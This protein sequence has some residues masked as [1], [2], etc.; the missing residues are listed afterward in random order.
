MEGSGLAGQALA[1]ILPYLTTAGNAIA[2]KVGEELWDQFRGAAKRLFTRVKQKFTT[3]AQALDDLSKLE[4]DPKSRGRQ[5]VVQEILSKFIH[6]D[7]EFA[8]E[9]RDLVDAARHAGGDTI[10]QVLNISNS[11]V[12]NIKQ[13][14][15]IESQD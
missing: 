1:L 10:T 8:Q 7:K 2:T 13:V 12:G 6:D 9:L 14:G 5:S 11:T 15:K 4:Q 3:N